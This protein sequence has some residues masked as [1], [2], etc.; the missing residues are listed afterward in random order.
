MTPTENR[1][2]VRRTIEEWNSLDGDVRRIRT[3]FDKRYSPGFVYHDVCTG[4]TDLEQTVRDMIGYLSAFPGLNYSIDDLLADGDKTVARCT[5]R[6]THQGVFRGIPAT[7]NRIVVGQ[8]EI[9]RIAEGKIAEAWGFSDSQ[10]M[11]K[12]L[13]IKGR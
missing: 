10:G 8:V 6:A 7:G 1:E 3:L 11:M 5:L 2:L 9:H 12:Q 4:D 13:R